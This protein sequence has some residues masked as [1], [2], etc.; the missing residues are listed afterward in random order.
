MFNMILIAY[1]IEILRSLD[2][3]PCFSR[4]VICKLLFADFA[5]DFFSAIYFGK[6]LPRSLTWTVEED[7]L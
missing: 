2:Y 6:I 4:A 5:F 3:T 7:S 1:N